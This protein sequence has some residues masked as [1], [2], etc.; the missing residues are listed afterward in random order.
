MNLRLAFV[1][2]PE[3][4]PGVS[5]L[6]MYVADTNGVMQAVTVELQSQ[7]PLSDSANRWERVELVTLPV[8]NT[9]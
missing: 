7:D 8:A 1:P 6:M 2:P 3:R 4:K 5:Y 9:P